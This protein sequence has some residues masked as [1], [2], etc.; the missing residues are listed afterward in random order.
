MIVLIG[1]EKGGTGK[2]TLAT[3][4]CAYLATAGQDILL[5]DADRQSTSASWAAERSQHPDLAAVHC[6][7]RY[8]NLYPAVKDLRGRYSHVVIDA[9][10]RD[11]EELRSAMALADKLYSP[12]KASQSDLWTIEHLARL[13][14][15]AR[16]FN[17]HLQA[18]VLIS[19]APTNPRINEEHEAA[20][21][22]AEFNERVAL[23]GHVTRERKAYRDAMGEGRGVIEMNDSKAANEI[24]LIAKE[25]YGE[26]QI[27]AR[28]AAG[29][30]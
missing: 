27:E 10:G 25:I 5:L 24:A 12:A 11:S 13:V 7:Q 19:M 21:M 23:S 4:L 16:G 2:S 3:N 20:K 22:L 15:L 6:V 17:P 29:A 18:R 8:G 1:G 28:T 9:G 30:A 26:I 14:D